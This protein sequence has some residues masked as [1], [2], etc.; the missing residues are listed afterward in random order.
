MSTP[1]I[2][3]GTGKNALRTVKRFASS[4]EYGRGNPMCQMGM[5]TAVVKC[6]GVMGPRGS[7]GEEIGR[8]IKHGYRVDYKE[9]VVK[10][11]NSGGPV[12]V[13]GSS[14]VAAVGLISYISDDDR[15]TS[16]P[17]QRVGDEIVFGGRKNWI[18]PIGASLAQFGLR[19]VVR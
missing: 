7:F 2:R 11:G 18:V 5:V 1:L 13:S 9:C 10:R 8:T 3:I 14:D 19:L 4:A 12:F 17:K 15:D 6:D 16:C